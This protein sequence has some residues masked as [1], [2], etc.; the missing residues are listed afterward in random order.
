MAGSILYPS[1]EAA[2]G[3]VGMGLSSIVYCPLT[4]GFIVLIPREQVLLLFAIVWIGDNPPDGVDRTLAKEVT[5][6]DTLPGAI[7]AALI[8]R[9]RER[10]G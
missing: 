2:L 6:E 7:T 4:L 1:T 5:S 3:R 9:R 10:A 8:A